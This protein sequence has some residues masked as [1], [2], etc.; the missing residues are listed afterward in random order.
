MR[1]TYPMMKERMGY[2]LN[3]YSEYY[4]CWGKF[5]DGNIPADSALG[6]CIARKRATG[7]DYKQAYRECASRVVVP[8]TPIVLSDDLLIEP[9]EF[10]E[11]SVLGYMTKYF[12]IC[13]GAQAT[14]QHLIV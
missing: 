4:R 9:V 5:Q 13:P 8:N 3:A 2:C 11:M 6:R 12:Y 7:I 10:S 14:F 1:E